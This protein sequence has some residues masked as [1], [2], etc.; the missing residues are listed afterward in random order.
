MKARAI[1]VSLVAMLV[2]GLIPI[3]AVAQTA[4][5]I[6]AAATEVKAKVGELD[7]AITGGDPVDIKAKA[8]ALGVAVDALKALTADVDYAEFDAAL[9]ALDAAITGG[10]A[11]EI[12]AAGAAAAAAANAAAAGAEAEAAAAGGTA[13]PT[14]VDSGDAVDGGPSMALLALAAILSLLAGGAYMVRRST[15]RS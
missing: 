14:A 7:T 3:A 6:T 13:E 8:D 11:A 5:E 9:L 2:V 10:D 12:A 15:V 4:D 1:L